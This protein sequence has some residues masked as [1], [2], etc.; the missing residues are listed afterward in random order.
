MTGDEAEFA[1]EHATDL[2]EA[3]L[4]A[5]SAESKQR[6]Q[7][8][9]QLYSEAVANLRI[10]IADGALTSDEAITWLCSNYNLTCFGAE[11]LLHRR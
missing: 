6:L 5:L 2:K 4:A 7:F 10:K 11:D 1:T 9:K 8:V 3:E